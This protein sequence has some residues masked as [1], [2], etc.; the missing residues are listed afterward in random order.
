MSGAQVCTCRFCGRDDLTP[1]GHKSHETHCDDNSNPGIPYD[2][3][4]QL[5]ILDES[6]K[7]GADETPDETPN[8]DQSV[9]ASSSGGGLPPVQ[10]LSGGKNTSQTDP[11]ATDG[12]EP[13]SCPLCGHDDVLPASEAKEAYIEAVDQPN[14]KAVLGYELA[15]L[16][17][18]N[19]QCAALWGEKYEEPLPMEA[20]V[21]A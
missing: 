12:S 2:Q 13:E 11:V 18:Q 19:P 16:S 5:G 6:Q 10:T 4:K 7:E 21:N 8:P 17:C 14:P 3:Q 15:D 20:V 1:Q 9:S